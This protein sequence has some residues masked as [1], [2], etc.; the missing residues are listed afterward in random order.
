MHMGVHVGHEGEV[1]VKTVSKCEV[2]VSG[3]DTYLKSPLQGM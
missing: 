1:K 3:N 2:T